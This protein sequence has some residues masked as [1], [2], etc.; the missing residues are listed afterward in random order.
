M[1]FGGT[2]QCNILQCFIGL[3]VAIILFL[4][5]TKLSEGNASWPTSFLQTEGIQGIFL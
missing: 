3:F 1:I 4:M 5:S 2:N